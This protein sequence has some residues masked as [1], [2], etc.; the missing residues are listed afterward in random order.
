M[1]TYRIVLPNGGSP[2]LDVGAGSLHASSN[3]PVTTFINKACTEFPTERDAARARDFI[4]A[5]TRLGGY[6]S[7]ADAYTAAKIERMEWTSGLD[8]WEAGERLQR[9]A[10]WVL[11]LYIEDAPAHLFATVEAK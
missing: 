8:T 7:T 4:A 1:F 2:S 6:P 10:L 5:A 3:L 9:T 11:P